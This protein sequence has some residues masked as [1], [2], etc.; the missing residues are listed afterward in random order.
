MVFGFTLRSC[1][2]QD[3]S[4]KNQENL[5]GGSPSPS[6][7]CGGL[8]GGGVGEGNQLQSHANDPKGS[9]DL[10]EGPNGGVR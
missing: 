9:A 1:S 8:V 5:Q 4:K 7:V 10:G 3:R 2:R 6:E